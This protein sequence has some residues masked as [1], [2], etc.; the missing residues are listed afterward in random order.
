MAEGTLKAPQLRRLSV[1][2]SSVG[3]I[4]A[5]DYVT[6]TIPTYNLVSGF[7]N[8]QTSPNRISW[9]VSRISSV[10]GGTEI[11]IMNTSSN[12]VQAN[13]WTFYYTVMN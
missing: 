3:N 12:V 10:I 7:V 6:I 4:P 1:S 11:R 5:N 2:G 13:D 8:L 9:I